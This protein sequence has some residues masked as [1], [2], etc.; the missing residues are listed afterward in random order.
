MIKL[1]LTAKNDKF[2][3]KKTQILSIYTKTVSLIISEIFDKI[4]VVPH[5]LI[6]RVVFTPPTST[7]SGQKKEIFF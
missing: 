7:I 3:V 5:S 4:Y 2:V 1:T 6:L